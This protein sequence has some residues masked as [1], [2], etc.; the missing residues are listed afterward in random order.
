MNTTNVLAVPT[1]GRQLHL[2][3][4]YD[5]CNDSFIPGVYLWDVDN[6]Q[7]NTIVRQSPQT[8]FK[9][10]LSD[11]L[12]EKEK[13]LQ[14][15]ASLSASV[16]AGLVNMEG[17]ASYLN[18]RSSSS[19]ECRVTVQ[20][21]V[22]TRTEHLN[23]SQIGNVTNRNIEDPECS[24]THVIVQVQYGAEAL[25]VFSETASD[26]NEKQDV[27]GNMKLMVQ[28]IGSFDIDGGKV[29]MTDKERKKVQ[30][31]TCTFHGDFELD[32][33][34]SNFEEVVKVYKELHR[35]LGP[36]KENVVPMKVWLV[37]L[38]EL[39]PSAAKL[40]NEVSERNCIELRNIMEQL[41]IAKVRAN[42][43][44]KDSESIQAT[45]IT[46]KMKD[47]GEN[48]QKYM[49]MWKENLFK[50]L[51]EIRKGAEKEEKLEKMFS[52]HAESLFGP[53][54]MD[55]W[56]K[57]RE[58]EIS[59]IKSYINIIKSKESNVQIVAREDFDKVRLNPS[60]RLANVFGFNSVEDDDPYLRSLRHWLDP[61][62]FASIE[63]TTEPYNQKTSDKTPW[64]R[65]PEVS[66]SMMYSFD[67]FCRSI[68]G[69]SCLPIISY[70]H[71]PY[72][73]GATFR[74]YENGKLIC[75]NN[76]NQYEPEIVDISANSITMRRLL[77]P[78]VTKMLYRKTGDGDEAQELDWPTS[79]KILVISDLLPS[80]EYELQVFRNKDPIKTYRIVT[81]PN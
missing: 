67:E 78:A 71:Y 43:L 18:D 42:D 36:N 14:V 10:A 38:T 45:D 22:R 31:F 35:L 49:V 11:S 28:N 16:H 72:D 34:P 24:A 74:I 7:K 41:N 15:S 37:P 9:I 61:K 44:C 68:K 2:G 25:M 33:N 47:F 60:F 55:P 5:C 32:N 79:K 53:S 3:M 12:E 50:L 23:M 81:K 6:I 39:V 21:S 70:F 48:L 57:E 30:N 69:T 65:A 75:I 63:H 66:K 80:T 20:Y 26:E 54:K 56:L 40:K 8:S 4:L 52:L 76:L 59:V 73:E 29:Q 17:S 58:T 27:E 19:H 51:P 46:K 1:L 62:K 13:M 64:Y 77:K